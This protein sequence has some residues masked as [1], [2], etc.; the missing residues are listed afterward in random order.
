MALLCLSSAALDFTTTKLLKITASTV[1]SAAPPPLP[2]R[3]RRTNVAALA[4][5][6]SPP[7]PCLAT[8]APTPAAPSPQ[9][10]CP[11]YG[12]RTLGA[13]F[14]KGHECVDVRRD[15][16]RCG[17]CVAPDESLS[18]E[19]SADGG[20]DC[21]AIPHVDS[22]TCRKGECVIGRCAPGYVVSTDGERCVASF[23][24]QG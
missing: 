15:L 10:S 16:E 3:L 22:V 14:L 6:A 11:V 18:G 23:N 7:V 12:S 2:E 4:T 24:V 19:R 20:R 21:S 9:R 13:G 17:G 8:P 1:P 5:V